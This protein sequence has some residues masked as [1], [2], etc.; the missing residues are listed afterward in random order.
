YLETV[1]RA[2]ENTIISYMRDMNKFSDFMEENGALLRNA[3]KND[4]EHYLK[5]LRDMG[6]SAATITRTVV[7]IR[8]FYSWMCDM[9]YADSNPAAGISPEK[10]VKKL[11]E[12]L[13]EQEISQLLRQPRCEDMKGYRDKAMLELMYATGIRVSEL[14]AL[15]VDSVNLPARVIKCHGQNGERIIPLHP[16]AVNALGDYLSMIRPGMLSYENE[17]ALFVNVNG[18]RLSRQ[19]FWKIVKYYARKAGIDKDITPHTLRHSF[20]AHLL[21]NGADLNSL[22]EMLGHSDISSTQVYT[23]LVQRELKDVYN[24][25]H[26]RSGGR[27]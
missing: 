26:P 20:A 21:E 9:G 12:I 17:Q 13:T 7:S 4:I 18:D 3:D 11:P 25:A 10:P 8:G 22:K 16:A 15:D 5:H 2:S 14:I 24:K 19:G 1:K 6:R 27:K 23:R